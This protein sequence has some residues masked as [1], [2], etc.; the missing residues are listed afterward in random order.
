M[1]I[2]DL[3]YTII[4]PAIL[5]VTWVGIAIVIVFA[6]KAAMILIKKK[7]GLLKT[8]ALDLIAWDDRVLT[9]EAL[10]VTP[11][12]MLEKDAKK[13]RSKNF[14]LAKPLDSTTNRDQNII[15]SERDMDV[16]PPYTLDGIP[17]SFSHISK[18]IA[19]NPRVLTALRIANRITDNPGHRKFNS[20]VVLPQHI[21]IINEEGE[22]V[23]T[24]TVDVDVKLPFDPVDIKKNFSSYWQQSNIDATKR[25][26]Q[27]IG[28][29]KAKQG[30]LGMLKYVVILCVICVAVTVATLV[31]I[32]FATRPAEVA[33]PMT[34]SIGFF[35]KNLVQHLRLR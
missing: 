7:F 1:N 26:N 19:T 23:E 34:Q 4:L 24:N 16:L 27:A 35:F 32:Y 13:G 2:L 31:I 30:S 15:D 28:V 18:A 12:G 20:K 22:K 11:E 21:T 14:Y 6:P 3:V 9:L 17:I 5:A 25:R 29:E 10:D 33:A 8:K